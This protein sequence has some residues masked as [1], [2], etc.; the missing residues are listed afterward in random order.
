MFIKVFF[1][2]IRSW[3]VIYI[4]YDDAR[5]TNVRQGE[6]QTYDYRILEKQI[7]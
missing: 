5:I 7:T 4:S 6:K 3:P 2:L 1:M